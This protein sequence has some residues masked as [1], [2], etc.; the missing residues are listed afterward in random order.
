M[1]QDEASTNES[2][3][4][5]QPAFGGEPKDI[6][7][8]ELRDP[9]GIDIVAVFAGAESLARARAGKARATVDCARTRSFVAH[10]RR[11]LAPKS[12]ERRSA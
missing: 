2:G 5:P 8:H 7:S 6:E 4:L 1:T 12:L 9:E 3:P 11:F 10:S